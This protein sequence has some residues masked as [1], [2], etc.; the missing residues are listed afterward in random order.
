MLC[1]VRPSICLHLFSTQGS[2]FVSRTE[3]M[4]SVTTMWWCFLDLTEATAIQESNLQLP[5]SSFTEQW[6]GSTILF[7]DHK[8]KDLLH[9]IYQDLHHE[10]IPTAALLL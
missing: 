10:N 5:S 9:D 2:L 1:S 8:K 6:R 4:H 3:K 7:Q